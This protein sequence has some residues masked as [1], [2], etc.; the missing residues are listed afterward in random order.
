MT[1]ST[2]SANKSNYNLKITLCSSVCYKSNLPFFSQKP[3]CQVDLCVSVCLSASVCLSVCLFA[4]LSLLWHTWCHA[5]WSKRHPF[6]CSIFTSKPLI[7]SQ[8]RLPPYSGVCEN[9]I[10]KILSLNKKQT[11]ITYNWM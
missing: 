7:T 4:N 2:T 8:C 3:I 9:V 10:L 1:Y 11:I 6:L 5:I